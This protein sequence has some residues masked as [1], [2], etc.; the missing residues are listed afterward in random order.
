MNDFIQPESPLNFNLGVS[1]YLE[2]SRHDRI[3]SENVS[4]EAEIEAKAIQE[5]VNQPGDMPSGEPSQACQNTE[6][7]GQTEG[8][9]ITQENDYQSGDTVLLKQSQDEQSGSLEEET[10]NKTAAPLK[11]YRA[12]LKK[13]RKEQHE[14][15]AEVA[16]QKEVVPSHNIATQMEMASSCN[17]STQTEDWTFHNKET[18]TVGIPSHNKST[19]TTIQAKDFMTRNDPII[20]NLQEELAQAQLA[21]EWL[22]QETVS[23][24]KY[25]ELKRQLQ[26]M[27]K[28]KSENFD[29]CRKAKEKFEK[30]KLRLD[31]VIIQTY[32]LCSLYTDVLAC[33]S[34]ANNYALF[35]LERYLLLKIKAVR[36][37]KPIEL[38]TIE[39]FINFCK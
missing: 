1:Q 36:A 25:Q 19:Q 28:A 21:L 35:L 32:T 31:K 14:I 23:K 12:K 16:T 20:V 22:E 18:Q 17:M 7:I 4:C 9:E 24:K 5:E 30:T 3:I 8:V 15:L 27:K 10:I 6:N 26:D 39:D 29:K 11:K 33:I 13:L 37:G 2:N 38:K 34:P